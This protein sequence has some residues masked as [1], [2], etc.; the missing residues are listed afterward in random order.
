M[1][2]TGWG[3][4]ASPQGYTFEVRKELHEAYADAAVKIAVLYF[5]HLQRRRFFLG[6]LPKS[7]PFEICGEVSAPMLE[8][9]GVGVDGVY[10]WPARHSS[11]AT[12]F[13]QAAQHRPAIS[14]LPSSFLFLYQTG[15]RRFWTPLSCKYF[16]HPPFSLG[17]TST[18]KHSITSAMFVK[19]FAYLSTLLNAVWVSL[20]PSD[21]PDIHHLTLSFQVCVLSV[22][23][24][25]G[26]GGFLSHLKV[27]TTSSQ[28][29][30]HV[31]FEEWD[32]D[33]AQIVL[34]VSWSQ[35]DMMHFTHSSCSVEDLRLIN[36]GLSEDNFIECLRA[37]ENLC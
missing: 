2:D 32:D 10:I 13:M 9:L 6:S 5:R 25:C 15:K 27:N 14:A 36:L 21:G 30:C 7:L 37:L 12:Q 18:S 4:L 24:S 8:N 20:S 1:V 29:S 19:F 31:G 34:D 3:D 33:P 16:L 22:S 11:D 35:S 26:L 28:I 23:R 17:L